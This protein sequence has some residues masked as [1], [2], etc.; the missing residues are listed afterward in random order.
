MAPWVARN[1]IKADRWTVAD[2]GWMPN[3]L[4]GT[5]D[6]RSGSNRWVQI[7]EAPVGK[8]VGV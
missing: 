6:L 8:H 4:I 3:L 7:A 5:L 2:A 1:A